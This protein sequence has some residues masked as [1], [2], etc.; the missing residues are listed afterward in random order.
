MA[1]FAQEFVAWLRSPEND[2]APGNTTIKG[3]QNLESGFLED[4]GLLESK[5]AAPSCGCPHRALLPQRS[6][7]TSSGCMGFVFGDS[8]SPDG[9]GERRSHRL[10]CFVG[11]GRRCA[12][13]ILGPHQSSAGRLRTVMGASARKKLGAIRIRQPEGLF[14][15]RWKELLLSSRRPLQC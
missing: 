4:S 2:R 8:R 13:R 10:L 5:A 6:F 12:R 14:G 15:A 9:I 7:G 1:A 3:C 11:R